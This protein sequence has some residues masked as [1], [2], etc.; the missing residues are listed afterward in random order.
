M[1]GEIKMP[2]LVNA[3]LFVEPDDNLLN[4]GSTVLH[5]IV[6]SNKQVGQSITELLGTDANPTRIKQEIANSSPLF[7]SMVGHGNASTYTCQNLAPLLDANN[8][9]ELALITGRVIDLCS[10]LTAVTLGPALISAG[11]VSYLGYSTE[12]W[13]YTGDVAGT[14]RAVQSPFLAEFQFTA[15]IL[16]G[17]STGDA[18]T[19]QLAKYDEEIAYWTTGVGKDYVDASEL[20]QVLQLNKNISTFLG[21]GSVSPSSHVSP[22]AGA[23]PAKINPVIPFVVAVAALGYIIYKVA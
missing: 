19:D 23:L 22:Q 20:A 8:P 18:R 1:F 14:T 5:Q 10:C 21:A 3:F 12:F 9:T 2:A 7:C 6:Q 15:S 16:Q 13:F 17:K 11:A 4:Y